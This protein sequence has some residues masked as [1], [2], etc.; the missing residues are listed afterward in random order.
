MLRRIAG[1]FAAN[2]LY[3]VAVLTISV[4]WME[5][6]YAGS[7]PALKVS[8]NK[9]FLV[10]ADGQPFF[11]LGD[12]AW[13][14]FHRLNREEADRYLRNRAERRFTVIQT[15]ALAELDGLS[16]PN[17]YGHRPLLNNDPAT[18][19]VRDGPNNDYW[20]H[21]DYIVDRAAE[22]GM[23]IGFLPTWGDKWN[24]RKGAGPEVF[25]P[26]NA[27]AY[28][29]WLGKR[30]KDRTNIIWILGGDRSRSSTASQSMRIIPYPSMSSGSDIRLRAMCGGRSTGICSR[31][32]SATPMAT[33]RSGRCGRRVAIP[34]TTR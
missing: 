21:V 18:P 25:T 32:R 1:V 23:Y 2:R 15:V 13:E 27:E 7:L 29:A 5:L 26:Q 24:I 19:D 20:D 28:G 10:T 4:V 22:L 16:D 30:Y 6:L 12:T 11:W 3:L 31:A 9:R 17:P 34:S 33:I 14:L 8:E